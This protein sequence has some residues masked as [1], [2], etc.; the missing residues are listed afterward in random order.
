[1][2]GKSK[3]LSFLSVFIG[4]FIVLSAFP[5]YAAEYGETYPNY[6][7]QSSACF[8]ECNTSLGKG[9]IVIPVN[10]RYDYLG[11]YGNGNDL[12]NCTTSTING[13]FVLTNGN[14]Y[15]IRAQSFSKF[16][17]QS[18]NGYYNEWYDLNVSNILNTNVQLD[19]EKGDRGNIIYDFSMYEKIVISLLVIMGTI[20]IGILFFKR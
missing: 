15:T 9:S 12:M 8:V 17:Y 20:V 5:V 10:Y 19:D 7:N 13:Q 11:F 16:Q 3:C 1:M 6:L 2:K 14:T 4:L 18:T